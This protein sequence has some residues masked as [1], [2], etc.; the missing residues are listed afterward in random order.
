[1]SFLAYD[2]GVSIWRRIANF[3]RKVILRQTSMYD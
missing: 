1:V 3:A 2:A